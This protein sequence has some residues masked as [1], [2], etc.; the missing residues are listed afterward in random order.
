M[1]GTREIDESA[2]GIEVLCED[3]KQWPYG[4]LKAE[5]SRLLEKVLE[6]SKVSRL[7]INNLALMIRQ[8][9]E[10]TRDKSIP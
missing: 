8:H 4:G 2:Q 1:G 6:M 5:A 9:G 7:T 10:S 3:V